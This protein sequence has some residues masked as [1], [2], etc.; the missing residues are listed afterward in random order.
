MKTIEEKAKAYDEALERANN[1]IENGDEYEKTVAESIFAGLR[2]SKDETIRK[3]LIGIFTNQSLCD[4]YNLK[5]EDVLAYL[6][7]QKEQKHYC[8]SNDD[9]DD[10]AREFRGK[11]LPP[12]EPISDELIDIIKGEFEGFRRLLKKKGIDYEPQRSYWEGFAR[13]FDSSAREYV[14]E[15][16]EQKPVENN[17]I[18][19]QFHIGD[20][21][22]PKAYNEE[23]LIKDINKNG[24]VLDID[25]IIPFK[26]EDVWQ[27]AEHKPA[28]WSEEDEKKIHFLSRLIEFQVKDDEYCFGD[29]TMITKQGAVEMLKSLR[30]SRKPSEEKGKELIPVRVK[31]IMGYHKSCGFV[32]TKAELEGYGVVCENGEGTIY[33]KK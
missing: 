31:P 26:D 33:I 15:Q 16:K 22:K 4:V 14:K 2:E 6:E 17:V 18:I 29:G 24:Y 10:A 23:H 19:P 21:I 3:K 32:A 20:Y 13:L 7:R 30:P 9:L 8:P 11:C 28:E 5:S 12:I 27:L 1:F 25:M